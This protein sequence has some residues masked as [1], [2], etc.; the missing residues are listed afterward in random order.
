MS[1][2][3]LMWRPTPAE[4]PPSAAL[5]DELATLLYSWLV[6][7]DGWAW[8]PRPRSNP[9]QLRHDQRVAGFLEGLAAMRVAGAQEFAQELEK[10]GTIDL[11]WD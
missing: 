8:D 1:A 4:P 10:H 5:P 6:A 11:W 2:N 3:E 7:Q 9:A